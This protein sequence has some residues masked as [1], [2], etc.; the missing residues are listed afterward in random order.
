M[1]GAL[2]V[3]ASTIAATNTASGNIAIVEADGA[4]FSATNVGS[5]TISLTTTAGILAIGAATS[6][7]SGA[8]NLAGAGGINVNAAIT[9]AST[10][11]LNSSGATTINAALSN[12]GSLQTD[13]SGTTT[14]GGGSVTTSGA[15]TYNDAVTL[16]AAAT[17]TGS[18]ITFASTVDAAFDLAVNTAGATLF[19]GAVSGS[20]KLTQSGSG[21]A[22]LAATNLYT[23]ATT[24]N[25]GT[26]LVNGSIV[27][28]TAVNNTAT[29]GGTGSVDAVTVASGGTLSPGVGVSAGTLSTG[30]VSLSSGATL[31]VQL[32]GTSAGQY[33]QLNVSGSVTLSGATLDL[34]LI[35]S[36][37]LAPGSSF[38][39]V[40]NDG[41][42]SVT[43]TFAGLTEGSLLS[44]N[45]KFFL[46]TY[47][48]GSNA[49]DVV[50]LTEIPPL[51]HVERRRHYR[52][53]V[54]CRKY[55]RGHHRDGS[56]SGSRRHAD[57]FDNRRL[58]CGK[59]PDRSG[60]R[61]AV[62][63]DRTGLRE[64][65]RRRSQ[66]QLHRPGAR[67]RRKSVRRSNPDRRHRQRG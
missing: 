4:S 12:L 65:D 7:G 14:I 6:S 23:G 60:E 49:N 1:G 31:K 3:V 38:T 25:A 35:N 10:L 34:A 41:A 9:T 39:I 16:G 13:A 63:C 29:L 18:T 15:Q 37:N 22:T 2:S 48:G 17:L 53:R 36:F 54:S 20:G 8:I 30:D 47:H 40:S 5:G 24:V 64:P 42:D 52:K 57:V 56:G 33:D 51:D 43:G 46:I 32:G 21:T 55:D 44:A 26:L 58:R 67:V 19:S 50:L 11:A 28:D 59:I 45:G 66:Q 27:S 61:R 62:F